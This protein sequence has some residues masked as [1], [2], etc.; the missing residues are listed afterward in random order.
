[1]LGTYHR[2]MGDENGTVAEGFTAPGR[3]WGRLLAEEGRSRQRGDVRPTTDGQLYGFQIGVDL[4]RFGSSAGHHD[5]G[6]YGG[7]TNG[8]YRVRGFAS[9]VQNVYVGRVEPDAAYA[10]LY[11]TYRANNGLYVDTVV[12][13]SWYGGKATAVNGNRIGI[14]GVGVLASVEGGY[15]VPVSST[16]TIEPQVQVIA[17]GISIDDTV[18]PNAIVR[19]YSD[20]QI[21]GRIGLRAKGRMETSRGSVQPYL[22]ANIW[23]AFASTDRTIFETATARTM[24]R[25]FNSS[26]WGDAGAGFTWS[27]DPNIAVYGEATHRF[28]LDKSNGVVGHSTGGSIGIKFSM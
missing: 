10:G 15:A 1:V 7:Y 22:R 26:L 8:K 18:I 12:Q 21:T 27:L 2:R 19:Q 20:G 11:W 25:T 28:T 13:R 4:F 23:K 3:V 14:D 5:L 6:V 16:W 9:G 24:I 17:Q